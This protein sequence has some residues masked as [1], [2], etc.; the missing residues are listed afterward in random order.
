MT[1][2]IPQQRGATREAALL[3]GEAWRMSSRS[4]GAKL[5]SRPYLRCVQS[6]SPGLS[7]GVG[8]EPT[9]C[10]EGCRSDDQ[11]ANHPAVRRPNLAWRAK[12][13]VIR[14]PQVLHFLRR[15]RPCPR[16]G[17]APGSLPRSLSDR[18]P[19]MRWHLTRRFFARTGIEPLSTR[20]RTP[21]D[22]PEIEA[23]LSTMKG[24]PDY[25]GRFE[26]DIEEILRARSQ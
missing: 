5:A 10:Q 3:A 25:P 16:A 17:R 23:L 15:L 8:W 9:T 11:G 7:L 21:D 20:S 19:K 6:C 12:A 13:R 14:G 22:N 1:K 18:G 24:R 4:S 2:E 26:R